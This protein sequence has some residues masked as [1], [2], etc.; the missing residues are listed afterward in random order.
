[1]SV[2]ELYEASP[3]KRKRATAEEVLGR[4]MSDVLELPTETELAPIES[5]FC[6]RCDCIFDDVE[7]VI[8][9]RAADLVAQWERADPRDAWRHTGEESPPPTAAPLKQPY[10]TPTSTEQ[11]F[12]YVALNE[13]PDQLARWL[14]RHPLD[15]P[16]LIEIWKHRWLRAKK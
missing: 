12:W 13:S 8:F 15:A 10:S 6:D 14:E 3:I 7:E 5:Q 4:R 1:M 2:T 9:L 16:Y 11:A